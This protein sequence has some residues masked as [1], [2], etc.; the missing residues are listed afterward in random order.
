VLA[1]GG[2]LS[3]LGPLPLDVVTIAPEA[4]LPMFVAGTLVGLAL[5]PAVVRAL[6]A[7]GGRTWL[8]VAWTALFLAPQGGVAP[9]DRLLIGP[10]IGVA[11][12]LALT[13]SAERARWASASRLRR[14]VAWTLATSVLVGSGVF[15]VLQDLSLAGMARHVRA[16]ILATD[17]GERG[18]RRDVLVL[19]SENQIQAFALGA[20]WRAELDDP[21][22]HFW[23]LQGGPRALRW[24]RL[25]ERAFEMES[26]DEPFL[27]GPFEAVYRSQ[28]SPPAP[29]SRSTTPLFTVE[30]LEIAPDGLRRFRVTLAE[31]LDDPSV[32]FVR[33][34]EGVLTRIAPPAPGA[35][36]EL[37]RARSTRPFVP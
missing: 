10:S 26:L 25:D 29:G 13:W 33:P 3:F 22:V 8:L 5:A 27:T 6:R 12:I 30:P 20:T 21:D 31:S 16:K 18:G 37:E 2:V 32:L 11:G 1:G 36:I 15:L 34:L 35:T 19:Q 9:S 7:S 4:R 24:T 28:E 17:V 14:A 23:V